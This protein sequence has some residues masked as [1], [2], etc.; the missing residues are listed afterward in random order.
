MHFKPAIVYNIHKWSSRWTSKLRSRR[1]DRR[2]NYL[3]FIVRRRPVCHK[4]IEERCSNMYR[5]HWKMV[6]KKCDSNKYIK[7]RN[8]SSKSR[9]KWEFLY[10]QDWDSLDRRNKISRILL[11]P[12][13]HLG[14]SL[15]KNDREGSEIVSHSQRTSLAKRPKHSNKVIF[16]WDTNFF[17]SILRTGNYMFK[18]VTNLKVSGTP[19]SDSQKSYSSA[20]LHIDNRF[21]SNYR[22]LRHRASVSKV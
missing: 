3:S 4:W 11:W 18:Q 2:A 20:F 19:K 17:G 21:I 1:K 5:H 7:I 22:M 14:S 16:C 9:F 13:G 6:Q 12:N 8:I 15:F 10:E